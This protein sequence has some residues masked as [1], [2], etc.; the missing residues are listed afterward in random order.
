MADLEHG[1]REVSLRAPRVYK[2]SLVF[3]LRSLLY[4][5]LSMS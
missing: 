5:C 2:R 1:V 3:Q 4:A